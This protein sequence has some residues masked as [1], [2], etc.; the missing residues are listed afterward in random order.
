MPI[1]NTVLWCGR[2]FSS[3]NSNT[4]S[5]PIR[6]HLIE[7]M[8]SYLSSQYLIE[9]DES[10]NRSLKRQRRESI[11]SIADCLRDSDDTEIS[12]IQS[13]SPQVQD[14]YF[15]CRPILRNKS[16]SSCLS[17]GSILQPTYSIAGTGVA[18]RERSNTES[19]CLLKSRLM[20]TWGWFVPIDK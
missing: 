3:S 8:S 16:I 14:E 6:I 19:R 2:L 11:S 13:V 10:Y 5:S 4:F 17:D 12:S 18:G 9:K 7:K 1:D 20:S 15:P